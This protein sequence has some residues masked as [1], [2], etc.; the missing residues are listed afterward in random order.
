M[1]VLS[2]DGGLLRRYEQRAAEE[3]AAVAL[4]CW[5]ADDGAAAS[6][7]TRGELAARAR[8]IAARV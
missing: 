7:I 6:S 8:D 1:D 5:S 2:P 3:P 4:R